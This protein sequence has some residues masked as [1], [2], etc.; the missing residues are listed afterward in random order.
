[1]QGLAAAPDLLVEQ[2]L[3]RVLAAAGRA[4]GIDL[5]GTG[6]V[7]PYGMIGVLA[8]GR[9]MG[10]A[11]P[12][13][14][15]VL[16]PKRPV[17]SY[18][19]RMDFFRHAAGI[20]ELRPPLRDGAPRRRRSA[21]VL[22]EITGIEASADIHRIA[23]RVMERAEAILVRHL[24][25]DRKAIHGFVAALS[26][27]C[28][29]ILEHSGGGGWVGIQRYFFG[30]RLQ[31]SVVK[32]AVM[33][34]GIG[35]A[36]T[37]RPRHAARMGGKWSDLAAIRAALFQGLSRFDDPG[38]GQGLPAV[39]RFA[40]LWQGRLSLRSGTARA[41]LIPK[42]SFG[43]PVETGLPYFPGTQVQLVLPAADEPA[44]ES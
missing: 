21:D 9:I 15:L 25:Y 37:L 28:Q 33:D 31:R 24:R 19:E 20:F 29:N 40:E 26:E 16:S 12:R 27:V 18:L 6:F 22:L 2:G 30:G 4:R 32:I 7:D 39:R 35:L 43:K 1:M 11:G 38:R 17:A 13:P 3:E 41:S 8:A 42:W 14:A 10:A 34:T 23:E 5:S 36:E 44:I